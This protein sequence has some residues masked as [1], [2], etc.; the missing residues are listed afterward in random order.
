MARDTILFDINETVLD[1]GALRPKFEAVFGDANMTGTWFAM[2][3]HS[4]TVCALTGVK[5][6]FGALAGAMVDSLAARTGRFVSVDNRQ[7]ILSTFASLSPYP[8][9]VPA[10]QKL[11][12]AGF[13]TVAFSNSSLELVSAQIANAGLEE[14]F[15]RVIS[16]EET[17]S[18]K[19]DPKVYGFVSEQVD[20]SPGDLRLVATHDWD[21]HGAM[22][23]GLL[24]A[25]VQR[26]GAP[27]HPLFER[28]DI[29]ADS[30]VEVAD[31]II[32]A[33]QG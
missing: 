31:G 2:L 19:P 11:R 1:L 24:A 12:A 3:L 21:T 26:S 23:A 29:M 33:G 9:V 5:T 6:G 32:A 18:F 28:P 10:L 14:H 8:D 16:V 30:M 13:R 17:G 4:S 22:R 27:Y 7:F 20:R 15:D 25:F